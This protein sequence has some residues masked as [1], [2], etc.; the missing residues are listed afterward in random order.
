MNNITPNSDFCEEL[1][2]AREFKGLSLESLAR[3]T[4]IPIEYLRALEDGEFEVIPAAI[5]RGVIAEYAKS[6][7]MNADK[8]LKS[9]EEG[10][11]LKANS[12]SGSLDAER[13]LGESM[14]IGMT[15]VQIRT[16]WF[17]KIA[18]NRPLHWGITLCFLIAVSF[19]GADWMRKSGG[20]EEHISQNPKLVVSARSI[21]FQ[22]FEEAHALPDGSQNHRKSYKTQVFST[23]TGHVRAT[24]G[25]D[26]WHTFYL[27]P[28]D[29][30]EFIHQSGLRINFGANLRIIPTVESETFQ[31][32][33]SKDSL[34]A[35]ISVPDYRD[36]FDF[37]LD[38]ELPKPGS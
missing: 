34:E 4:R 24:L 18:S 36:S 27:Y 29:T 35:W 16:A 3:T 31:T 23:D 10:Q 28:Y 25:I 15:R 13:V 32:F 7:G 2:K 1:R 17:A 21:P 38:K 19:I 8:V 14:T 6:A 9:I 26:E 37:A 30:I 12:S 22:R 11:Q 20:A 33:Y 5:R